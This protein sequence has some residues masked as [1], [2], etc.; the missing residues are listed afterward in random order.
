[1]FF[2]ELTCI[3]VLKKEE[4]DEKARKAQSKADIMESL[5]RTLQTERNELKEK[6]K[7]YEPPV[8]VV[9]APVP[10]PEGQPEPV[11]ATEAPTTTQPEVAP[12]QTQNS[13]P[14]P[15]AATN[16]PTVE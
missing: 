16:T 4:T 1:M 14:E 13:N 7:T 10:V 9:A 6:L 3:I 8:V 2:Y 11:E 15:T 12:A 5:S